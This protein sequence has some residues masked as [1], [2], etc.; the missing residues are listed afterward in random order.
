MILTDVQ[1]PEYYPLVK[2]DAK[3]ILNAVALIKEADKKR[4]ADNLRRFSQAS[5][6]KAKKFVAQGKP[7]LREL[8]HSMAA[9]RKANL[10]TKRAYISPEI[11]ALGGTGLLAGY[12]LGRAAA[13]HTAAKI[14]PY[15][16]KTRSEDIARK[17]GVVTTP[18]G[19]LSGMYLAKGHEPEVTIALLRKFK[20]ISTGEANNIAQIGLPIMSGL[21]GGVIAGLGTGLVV[22]GTHKLFNHT[23]KADTYGGEGFE[24]K[25]YDDHYTWEDQPSDNPLKK[26]KQDKL[27][28]L[29]QKKAGLPYKPENVMRAI[30]NGEGQP[31]KY[32][33]LMMKKIQAATQV[34]RKPL[35]KGY[36]ILGV[37]GG[38]VKKSEVTSLVK[39]TLKKVKK[40]PW[41]E[42]Q[43]AWNPLAR[44]TT[45][46]KKMRKRPTAF[47]QEFRDIWTTG[48]KKI[49]PSEEVL[50]G[51][52]GYPSAIAG[53]TKH[54]LKTHPL[55]TGLP[56]AGT[57]GAVLYATRK[58]KELEKKAVSPE[59]ITKHVENGLVS[60]SKGVPVPVRSQLMNIIG[61]TKTPEH[62][63]GVAFGYGNASKTLGQPHRILDQQT[64]GFKAQIVKRI[65]QLDKKAASQVLQDTVSGPSEVVMTSAGAAASQPFVSKIEGKAITKH[66]FYPDEKYKVAEYVAD[67]ESKKPFGKKHHKSIVGKSPQAVAA[68]L[69]DVNKGKLIGR[70]HPSVYIHEKTALKASTIASAMN[71]LK[72]EALS[73]V[74]HAMQSNGLG[75]P[76]VA[77]KNLMEGMRRNDQ[78]FNII[79]KVKANPEYRKKFVDLKLKTATD[80]YFNTM[81]TKINKFKETALTQLRNT[82]RN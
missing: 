44:I 51:R 73:N 31:P 21:A 59:W 38:I 64:S 22:G 71:K 50:Q 62:A 32:T 82:Q 53:A 4:A 30:F 25:G 24:T 11:L 54:E 80:T 78:L 79:E 39:S 29:M 1:L 37:L 56:L 6:D 5:A 35:V 65:D 13:G 67:M 41:H 27:K 12:G 63:A 68:R 61:L 58:K 15:G 34:Q 36:P 20:K 70:W 55:A 42:K 43:Y 74:D 40:L 75:N 33:D 26:D 81:N 17:A 10:L 19:A 45:E 16:T 66:P 9:E 23:K 57:A 46:A 49:H 2:S 8:W 28:K 47:G 14:A 3:T 77:A 18:L 72:R 48:K 76:I 69:K 60:R 7:A 52:R